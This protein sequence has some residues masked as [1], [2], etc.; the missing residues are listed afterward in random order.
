MRKK[1]LYSWRMYVLLLAFSAI[2]IGIV[3]TMVL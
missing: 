2:N 3:R 1:W